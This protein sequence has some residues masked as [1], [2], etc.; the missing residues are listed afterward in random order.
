M[1]PAFAGARVTAPIGSGAMVTTIF[2]RPLVRDEPV[3]LTTFLVNGR[4]RDRV[5]IVGTQIGAGDAAPGGP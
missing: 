3:S 4:D 5:G 2:G 1:G